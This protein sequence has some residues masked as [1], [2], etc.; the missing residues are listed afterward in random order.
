MH[1]ITHKHSNGGSRH[2]DN[3]RFTEAFSKKG[4]ADQFMVVRNKFTKEPVDLEVTIMQTS[5][6]NLRTKVT[7]DFHLTYSK[8]GGNLGSESQ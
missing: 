6:K 5:R 8:N 4:R 7:P 3:A 2:R 1:H